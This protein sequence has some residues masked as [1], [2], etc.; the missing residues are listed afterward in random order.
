ML[1]GLTLA[2]AAP[3]LALPGAAEAPM[4]AAYAALAHGDGIAAEAELEK[5]QTA[6]ASREDVAAAM[7]EALLAQGENARAREWLGPGQFAKGQEAFGW[8]TLGRLERLDGNL[9]AAGQA[10]D[11][12][13]SFAPKDALLWVE[14]GRL[15]YAG[16]EQLQAIDASLKALEYGPDNIRALEFRAQ[17][18]R[19][20]QGWEAA[21]PIYERALERAPDDLS[22]LGGYAACL[23]ELGRG[24]EM[25]TVTRHMIELAPKHPYA[26]FLQATLAARVGDV[27]LARKLLAHTGTAMR[28]DPAG[29]LLS[30]VLELEAGNANIA[31]GQF[32]RLSDRQAANP[33][34][35]LLLARALYEAGQYDE[36][37]RRFGGYAARADAPAYLLTLLGRAYEDLGNRAAA[38]PLLDRASAATVPALMPIP[39]GAPSGVLAG[40]FGDDPG[41]PGSAVPYARALL[42][43]GNFAAA[44]QVAERFLSLHPG[45]ADA[46]ALAGDV[47]LAAGNPGGALSHYIDSAQ[48]RFPD[49]L[50]LRMG[51]AFD[52]AGRGGEMQPIAARYLTGWPGSR[53]AARLAAGHSAGLG[54]WHTARLLLESLRLRGGDGDVRLLADLSLAQLRDGDAEAALATAQTAYALMPS[55][56]V[57]A[58]AWG[59]ALAQLGR[60]PALARQLLTKA[61][62][63][64]G[65]N[66]LLVE[67]R[68]KLDSGS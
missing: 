21:L 59:M 23:G 16:G 26:W 46:L 4:K 52:R 2:L 43:A 31:V 63:I 36:L 60:E 15:R 29:M 35:Q 40:R 20:A 33:R 14:I 1:T 62:R 67:A 34:V 44:R 22:L 27:D 66:P 48:V 18:V 42:G 47:E 65:D 8:R 13:L 56:G 32:E 45:S 11:R 10:L 3:G 12:A 17:L 41:S 5:A 64:G 28:D 53:L 61:R 50:L 54:D 37:L 6:G 38:A 68:H 9:P 30:G 49:N 7:G 51:E 19:D 57:V 39:E 24:S 58:Q 55:S 25:L